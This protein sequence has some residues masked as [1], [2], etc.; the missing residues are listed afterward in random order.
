MASLYRSIAIGTTPTRRKMPAK[1]AGSFTTAKFVS[2][3][4]FCVASS[5]SMLSLW[6]RLLHRSL[7]L[8]RTVY[9]R[10]E[11]YK[12]DEHVTTGLLFRGALEI[13]VSKTSIADLGAA[14]TK[15]GKVRIADL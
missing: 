5:T 12:N 15:V 3:L 4:Y 8:E 11:R 10:R 2:F 1:P 13:L 9:C 7:Y 14:A 6:T